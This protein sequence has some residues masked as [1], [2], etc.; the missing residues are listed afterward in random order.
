MLLDNIIFFVCQLAALIQNTLWNYVPI[1]VLLFFTKIVVTG[2][3]INIDSHGIISY[4]LY[5][6]L[7]L[8]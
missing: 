8:S 3:Y 2:F 4:P 1:V 5:M 6:D 7:R